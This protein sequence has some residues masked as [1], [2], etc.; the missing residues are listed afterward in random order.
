[1]GIEQQ[2][3]EV[4]KQLALL[5][6]AMGAASSKQEVEAKRVINSNKVRVEEEKRKE[7]EGKTIKEIKRQ[8]EERKKKEEEA[9]EEAKKLAAQAQMVRDSQRKAAEVCEAEVDS[10]TNVDRNNLSAKDL[11]NLGE[12]LKEAIGMKR[13]IEKDRNREVENKVEDKKQ[14]VNGKILKT[15]R[16]VVAYMNPIDGKSKAELE[17]A[18]GETSKLLDKLAWTN[19]TLEWKV[20]ATA[21]TGEQGDKSL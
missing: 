16:I 8:A 17:R 21:G 9:L 10:L 12:K 15:V 3:E 6:A 2:L 20:K 4:K 7:V 19:S 14:V 1:M 13:K 18:V 5:A 11:I